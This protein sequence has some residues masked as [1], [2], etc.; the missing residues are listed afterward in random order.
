MSIELPGTME[1]QL[2]TLAAK[3]GRD[4]RAL[5]FG[6]ELANRSGDECDY[7]RTYALEDGVP[8]QDYDGSA[9]H[10]WRQFCPPHLAT[11]H[12][13]PAFQSGIRG[14]S[15]SNAA[16]VA[17]TWSTSTSVMALASRYCRIAS[18]TSFS[19]GPVCCASAACAG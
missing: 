14:N 10:R 13:S 3:Q 1:E 12:A 9:T 6:R 15:P 18:S 2:R 5:Y 16:C 8:G 7:N 17:P 19:G 4:V 11:S